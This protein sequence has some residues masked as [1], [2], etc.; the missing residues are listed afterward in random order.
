MAYQNELIK[1]YP[2]SYEAAADVT[3]NAEF[4]F[5]SACYGTHGYNPNSSNT[6][7]SSNR[8]QYWVGH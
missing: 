4:Y 7:S 5:N 6:V 8:C 3:F 1:I 2:T